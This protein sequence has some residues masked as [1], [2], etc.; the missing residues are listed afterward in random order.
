MKDF[1]LISFIFDKSNIFDIVDNEEENK[2]EIFMN[3]TGVGTYAKFGKVVTDYYLQSPV[4]ETIREDNRVN[5]SYT[6][7]FEPV[8]R[9]GKSDED[10]KI[11]IKKI[12]SGELLEVN[13]N[14]VTVHITT[15]KDIFGG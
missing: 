7:Q 3:R 12:K 1:K 8:V 5:K 9:I 6:Y 2:L 11:I 10:G 13:E 14:E 4:P 15:E